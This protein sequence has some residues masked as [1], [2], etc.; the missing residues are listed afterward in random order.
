MILTTNST[1]ESGMESMITVTIDGVSRQYPK[2]ISFEKI[3][4]EYQSQYRDMIALVIKNGKIREL[5]KRAEKDCELSFL[6]IRDNSGHKTYVRTSMMCWEP[7][8]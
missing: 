3:A 7:K 8:R 5:C 6:T 4:Q 2:G 1:A